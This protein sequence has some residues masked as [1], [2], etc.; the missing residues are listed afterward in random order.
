MKIIFKNT[1]EEPK[2]RS[3]ASLP[4]GTIFVYNHS[5][6][7]EDKFDDNRVFIKLNNSIK[8]NCFVISCNPHG[9]AGIDSFNLFNNWYFF[10]VGVLNLK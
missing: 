5:A 2:K 6:N 4:L 8:E 10:P 1:K 7:P 9:S 3:F